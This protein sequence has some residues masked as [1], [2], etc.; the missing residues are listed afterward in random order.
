MSDI[1]EEAAEAI[2]DEFLRGY[3]ME[4]MPLRRFVRL[5]K[6]TNTPYREITTPTGLKLL[7]VDFFSETY[8]LDVPKDPDQELDTPDTAESLVHEAPESTLEKYIQLPDFN[9]DFWEHPPALY[10]GTSEDSWKE[11]QAE[12]LLPMAETR[13]IANRGTGSAVFTSLDVDVP[14]EYGD[15]IIQID[16]AAM[17]RDGLTP[18]VGLETP[19]VEHE[20]RSAMAHLLRTEYEGDIEAGISGDTVVLYGS[21]PAKYLSEFDARVRNPSPRRGAKKPKN[22]PKRRPSLRSVMSRALK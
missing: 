20:L 14:A 19:I 3:L 1:D 2:L 17:K 4:K 13:G 11:I 22:K 7:V 8:V 12:G 18:E 21:V 9:R 16:T 6:L 5:L 10:H 15:V